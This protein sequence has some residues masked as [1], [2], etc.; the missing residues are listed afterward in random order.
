MNQDLC[1][2]LEIYATPDLRICRL[3]LN[4]GY[5]LNP[6][7]KLCTLYEYVWRRVSPQFMSCPAYDVVVTCGHSV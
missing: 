3:Y 6:F 4:S 7:E 5:K 2:G 1:D